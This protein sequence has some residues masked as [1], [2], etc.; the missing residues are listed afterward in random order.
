M[1]CYISCYITELFLWTYCMGC[2]HTLYLWDQRSSRRT[3]W[4][5]GFFIPCANIMHAFPECGSFDA[6]SQKNSLFS[7]MFL[8]PI[9]ESRQNV[10]GSFGSVGPLPLLIVL[11]CS[12]HPN[13]ILLDLV[14]SN[15]LLLEESVLDLDI[16]GSA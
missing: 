2:S 11:L 5:C 10:F 8:D 13:F 6:G 15:V 16:S 1:R 7:W 3:F 14:C 4:W 12:P 9:K